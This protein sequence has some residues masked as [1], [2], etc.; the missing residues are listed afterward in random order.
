MH[1]QFPDT[2]AFGR[3]MA[4]VMAIRGLAQ[5]YGRELQCHRNVA[6]ASVTR[7]LALP[8]AIHSMQKDARSALMQWLTRSGPFWE[9]HRY[10]DSD[11][12]LECKGEVVTD[13]AAGEAAYR[14]GQGIECG[15]VSMDPSSWLF[16]PLPVEWHQYGSTRSVDVPNYWDTEGLTSALD[17]APLLLASWRDL[18][19]IARERCDALTLVQDC[20]APLRG[21][22]FGD[23]PAKALLS[24]LAVLN[25]LKNSFE[26][27]GRRTRRGHEILGKHFSGEKA[28]FSDSSEKE[29]ARF[30][31]DLTFPHPAKA[32]ETLFCTWHGKVKT[33]QLRVHFTWPIRPS[34]P[35]YV[36]YVGPKITKR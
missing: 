9:D 19:A 14:L 10:H 1:G 33:P 16:S 3:A 11:D 17:A 21:L 6:N 8:Q 5:R 30:R 25:D 4:R 35:L 36:V 15:V 32:G 12:Y 13:T 26:E 29:K 23:A 27:D 34:A 2:T 7:D 31:Q 18:E 28:W 24:R 22:P 20:F